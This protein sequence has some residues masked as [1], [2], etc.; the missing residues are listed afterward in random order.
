MWVELVPPPPTIIQTS[1]TS[2]IVY[3]K[4][5]ICANP[6]RVHGREGAIM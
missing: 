6:P 3:H 5:F 1:E 4:A 2:T